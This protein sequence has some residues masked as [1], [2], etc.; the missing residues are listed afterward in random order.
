MKA[1]LP[2]VRVADDGRWVLGDP[3]ATCASCGAE[4]AVHYAENGRAE[5]WHAPTDCCEYARERERRFDQKRKDDEHRSMD[6]DD[7]AKRVQVT[8]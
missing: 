1:A 6:A 8:S 4:A 3:N 5:F 7:R 2:N